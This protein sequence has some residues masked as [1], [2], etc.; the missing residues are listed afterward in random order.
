LALYALAAE[1][2]L[3]R[4]CRR[5]ELHHL[6]SGEVAV[7]EHTDQTLARHLDRAE[8][9]AAEARAADE[10]YT[11]GLTPE[12]LDEI[13]PPRPGPQCAWCD[14]ARN[15]PEGARQFPSRRPWDGLAEAAS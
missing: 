7:W 11:T 6:P 1:R 3:R 5:V 15:C 2:S 10:A 12:R 9:L 8:S 4:R 14:L 13:F